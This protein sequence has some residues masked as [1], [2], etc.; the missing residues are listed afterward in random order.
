ML[1]RKNTKAFKTIAQILTTCQERHDREKLVR[2]YIT[3]AGTSI[4]ERIST[5]AIQGDSEVFYEM[6]YQSILVN[7]SSSNHQLQVSDDV[8]G[9]YF[10]HSSGNKVWDE[11]PFEFDDAIKKEFSE[12]PELPLTRKK[13]KAG[14]YEFPK[15]S[16]VT[17]PTGKSKAEVEKKVKAPKEKSFKAKMFVL[18]DHGPKQPDYKLRHEIHFTN[19]DRVISR[20]PQLTR[21]DIFDYYDKISEHILPYLKDRALTIRM[22]TDHVSTDEYKTLDELGETTVDIPDWMKTAS[23]SRH[24]DGLLVCNDKEHLLL[25]NEMGCHEFSTALARTKSPDA[26]DYLV[27]IVDS[28]E[29]DIAKAIPAASTTKQILDGLKLPSF[30]KSDGKSALHIYVPLDAKSKFDAAHDAARII[31][32]LIALKIP[33]LV[34]LGETE[35]YAYGKVSLTFAVNDE[36][37][38]LIAPY[39]LVPGPSTTVATPL[40]WEEVKEDLQ[41]DAFTH[42]TIFKRLKQ[43]GDPFEDLFRKK[44][45]AKELLE[46]L[47]ERYGFLLS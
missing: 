46:T 5:D 31:C 47:E 34:T 25:F 14:K 20:Q 4:N 6:N 41:L 13:E 3:R 29:H 10:F 40:L 7:L 11:T 42:E 30:I 9:I 43:V 12:L 21:K 35:E 23:T 26:P 36:S 1:I 37:K 32:N 8:P 44:V 17:K 2:L 33:D 18:R 16:A 45:N 22:Y 19:M 38:S 28:P 15:A 24:K 27:I 39:S